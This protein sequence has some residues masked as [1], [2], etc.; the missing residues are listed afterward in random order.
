MEIGSNSRSLD[1]PGPVTVPGVHFAT[2]NAVIDVPQIEF[3]VAAP[4]IITRRRAAG[5]TVADPA[6]VHTL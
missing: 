4:K 1:S 2:F 3:R 6:R 5:Q